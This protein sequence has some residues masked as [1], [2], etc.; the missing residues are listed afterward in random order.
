MHYC[1]GQLCSLCID[2]TKSICLEHELF[3]RYWCVLYGP[4]ALL[5]AA[6]MDTAYGQKLIR[7]EKK[8]SASYCSCSERALL[9]WRSTWGLY[10]LQ[11]TFSTNTQKAFVLL[12][13][14]WYFS[15]LPWTWLH[16]SRRRGAAEVR[17]WRWCGRVIEDWADLSDLSSHWVPAQT[18][19]S[20]CASA[21]EKKRC[22]AHD[23][24]KAH[25]ISW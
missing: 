16:L 17:W 21:G 12:A 25:K 23:C 11:V 22:D 18:M 6:S 15:D 3:F 5:F 24:C 1:F 19:S 7:Q 4:Q 13:S 14:I 10:A 2:F 9:S 8:S 20:A